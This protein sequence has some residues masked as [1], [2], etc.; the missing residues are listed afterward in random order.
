MKVIPRII[1]CL[2]GGMKEMKESI[3]KMFK[4]DNNDKELEFIILEMQNAV[5]WER[6][7]WIRKLLSGLLT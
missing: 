7:S 5:L 3:R 1:G 4:Y 2:G 6:E